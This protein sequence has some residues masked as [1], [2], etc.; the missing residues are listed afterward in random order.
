MSSPSRRRAA[1][2]LTRVP[3]PPGPAGPH[4]LAPALAAALDGTGPAIAPVPTVSASVSTTFVTS[5]L[6]A[7][8]PDDRDHPLESDDIA[9]VMPTSGSTGAPRGVLLTPNQLTSMSGTVNGP[10]RPQ[11]ILALPVTS[12][13]GLNV[14]IRAIGAGRD[15]VVVPS[16]GG[17]GP[18]TSAAFHDAVA[19]AVRSSDD[20]RVSLV[21]AQLSRLLADEAGVA[22]LR[23]CTSVLVGGGATRRPL[24]TMARDSG[25]A[26]T[27]TYGAT[28]TSGGCVF[29]GLPLPGVRLGTT[30]SSIGTPGILT[31]SGPCVATGYRLDPERTG[32]HFTAAGFVTSDLGTV[33]ADGS[34]RV[35]GRS[36]DVVVIN[37]V[38][39]SASAVERII[40]DLPD[41]VAAA[42][43]GLQPPDREA[44]LAAYVEVRD[45]A[46]G[47][48]SAALAAVVERLG[49][50]AGPRRIRRVGRLPHLPNGKVDRLLLR[51]WAE[52]DGRTD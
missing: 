5:V 15:P 33:A 25:V 23:A 48:E 24:L 7:V 30:G 22:A 40:A 28:E 10:G 42:A 21:P 29:D 36:D 43:I 38:N 4:L 11:W 37:G 41:V 17:A 52:A 14:L 13:G 45:D 31:I 49:V 32:R 46:P 39:V 20:V 26:V 6:R 3:V 44:W 1:R 18:F 34:V 19:E 16:I 9:V 35:L 12:M 27:T 2:L 51:E 8:R 47:V 50:A